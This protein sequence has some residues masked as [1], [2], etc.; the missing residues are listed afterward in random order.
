MKVYPPGSYW[1]RDDFTTANAGP[2]VEGGNRATRRALK[3]IERK[4]Y[5][6]N[7]QELI[8]QRWPVKFGRAIARFVLRAMFAR[9][10]EASE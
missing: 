2:A 6:K 3:K 10:S 1:V 7:R 9:I 5:V 4:A 8:A